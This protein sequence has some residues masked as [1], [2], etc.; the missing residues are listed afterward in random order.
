[1]PLFGDVFL[2][3]GTAD[4]RSQQIDT[5]DDLT[6]SL[7]FL[8]I[9]HVLWKTSLCR[10]WLFSHISC[11][12]KT[13]LGISHMAFWMCSQFPAEITIKWTTKATP[14][15]ECHYFKSHNEFPSW[16]CR[17]VPNGWPCRVQD[18]INIILKPVL[19]RPV[20][21]PGTRPRSPF[22]TPS[23][24]TRTRSRLPCSGRGRHFYMQILL[25]GDQDSKVNASPEKACCG[26]EQHPLSVIS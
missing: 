21:H 20:L 23:M 19:P 9:Y 26:G 17:D 1:M 6:S 4:G 16:W 7:S 10:F 24:S 14:V 18:V 2:P 15:W 8:T 22:S 25:H 11:L 12:R 13:P 5:E 3:S